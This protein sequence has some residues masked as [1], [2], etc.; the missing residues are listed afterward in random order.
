V[1]VVHLN[2][3]VRRCETS[4]PRFL[5]FLGG[6]EGREVLFFLIQ[7]GNPVFQIW[8]GKIFQSFLILCS[9]SRFEKK[10]FQSSCNVLT[11]NLGAEN[12]FKVS[13]IPC[14]NSP[15]EG[16]HFKVPKCR[17]RNILPKIYKF[18]YSCVPTFVS[19]K[20]FKVQNILPK[21]YKSFYS[22][23]PIFVSRKS[24]KVP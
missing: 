17:I 5:R 2:R 18:F 19:R 9:N 12:F 24:F 8:F 6:I 1:D 21:I 14:S 20:S 3:P 10:E 4:L 7:S 13:L 11:Q 16:K 23:V 15:F 22:C